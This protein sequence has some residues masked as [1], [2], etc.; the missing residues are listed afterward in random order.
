[1]NERPVRV[2]APLRLMTTSGVFK[3]HDKLEEDPP[4]ALGHPK[5]AS[6][7]KSRLAP[8]FRYPV[9]IHCPRATLA[10][11]MQ[12]RLPPLF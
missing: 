8:N 7:L 6:L 12:S 9:E 5:P 1:M 4:I 11:S 10:I 2:A 3:F